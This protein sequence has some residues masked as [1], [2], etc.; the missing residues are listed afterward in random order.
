MTQDLPPFDE[1]MR[2][3]KDEPEKLEELRVKLSQQTIDAAPEK[4]QPRL[5]G[6][7]FQVDAKR[8]LAKNPLSACI[9]ISEMMHQSFAEL[10]EALNMPNGTSNALNK[11]K[12]AVMEKKKVLAFPNS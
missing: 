2:M 5:R 10:Y 4:L 3:A 8:R 1:L 9:Q 11:H 6:L 12:D 7:Q